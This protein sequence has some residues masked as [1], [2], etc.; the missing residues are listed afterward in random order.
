V[1]TSVARAR[2]APADATMALAASTGLAVRLA[3]AH[4]VAAAVEARVGAPW[5]KVVHAGTSRAPKYHSLTGSHSSSRSSHLIKAHATRCVRMW[6]RKH[7]LTSTHLICS[8]AGTA[9]VSHA[10]KMATGRPPPYPQPLPDT[11]TPSISRGRL[12][13]QWPDR[14]SG[15]RTRASRDH[16]RA[17][18]CLHQYL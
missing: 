15:Q 13:G 4:S 14:K 8:A 6:P 3:R 12:D 10:S 1:A 5:K 11:H 18:A 9:A 17:G 7:T 16:G 2:M